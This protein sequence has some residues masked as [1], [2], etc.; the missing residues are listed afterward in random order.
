MQDLITKFDTMTLA[1]AKDG[2]VIKSELTPEQANLFM[3]IK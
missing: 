2:A 3:V 1:L